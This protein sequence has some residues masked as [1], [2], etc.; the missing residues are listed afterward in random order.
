MNLKKGTARFKWAVVILNAIIIAVSLISL[1]TIALGAVK[2]DIPDEDEFALVLDTKYEE[3][4]FITNFTITNHGLYDITN[5][6]IHAVMLT[7]TGNEL[8]CYDQA[9]LDIPAGQTRMYNI[10]AVL[11]FDKIDIDEWRDLMYNNSVFYLDVDIRADYL[12]GLSTFIVDETLEYDW[13][14][15][16]ADMDGT[17][18]SYYVGLLKNIISDNTSIETFVN[19]ITEEL[20]DYVDVGILEETIE[21]VDWGNTYLRLES[22]PVGA[23]A[24]RIITTVNLDLSEELPSLTFE[25]RILLKMEADGYDITLEGFSFTYG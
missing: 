13:V 12:W 15:P 20:R 24:W 3:V 5:L 8:I 4:N 17:I 14:A 2:V 11:P 7:E 6:D 10:V 23:D 1:F 9:D 22:W 25:L 16:L 19:M 18:D 21:V